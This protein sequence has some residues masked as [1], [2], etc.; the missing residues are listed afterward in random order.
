MAP[1]GLADIGWATIRTAYKVSECGTLARAAEELDVHP[2]T[3]VRRIDEIESAIGTKLFI[4]HQRG[5][6]LTDAGRELK[7]LV[8]GVDKSFDALLTRSGTRRQDREDHL[9]ISCVET[10]APFV[11]P[12]IGTF[13]AQ[14]PRANLRF[15]QTHDQV[16]L[17]SG[18]AHLS[19]TVGCQID[20][21]DYVHK[22]LG[23]IAFG[24]FASKS[25]AEKYG[26]PVDAADTKDHKFVIMEPGAMMKFVG[27]TAGLQ[28]HVPDEAIV[29][30]TDS[31][32]ALDNAI[33]LGIGIGPYPRHLGGT[34]NDLVE[35]SNA[36]DHI[37]V[38]AW[39]VT[40]KDIQ[41]DTKLVALIS[42]IRTRVPER[43]DR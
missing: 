31:I 30:R 36:R 23:P 14:Y 6:A 17:E 13:Q 29:F 1:D 8:Y 32:W 43:H 11:L 42:M 9:H 24:L 4:R 7:K 40:R 22:A 35:V 16:P 38:P 28:E 41:S 18:E 10:L 21:P 34:R 27:G 2:S 37:M 3:V 5:Y 25:Y 20:H 15:T 39:A 33:K 19:L 12:V 26:V